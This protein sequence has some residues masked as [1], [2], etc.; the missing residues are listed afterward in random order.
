MIIV[1][2]APIDQSGRTVLLSAYYT[3]KG[4]KVILLSYKG[5][6]DIGPIKQNIQVKYLNYIDT[7]SKSGIWKVVALGAKFIYL[8]VAVLLYIIWGL[9]S[10]R[11]KKAACVMFVVPPIYTFIVPILVLRMLRKRVIIDWHRVE[12]KRFTSGMRAFAGAAENI[13]VTE[14]MCRF[15]RERK[16][17]NVKLKTDIY[18][19]K[20]M[21]KYQ[22]ILNIKR[23]TREEVFTVLMEKYSEYR[24]NLI[25]VDQKAAIGV[26]STSFS[27]EENVEEM[28]HGIQEINNV[29]G[30]LILTT[31]KEINYNH[32]SIKIIRMFLDYPDYLLLLSVVDFGISTHQCSYDYPLKIVDY[33][34]HSIP[35]IAHSSTPYISDIDHEKYIFRYN[36]EKMRNALISK[37]F[38]RQTPKRMEKAERIGN[39]DIFGDI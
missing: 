25:E 27:A 20:K 11:R 39:E 28:L 19:S 32:P 8:N 26:C 36:T 5:C 16:V 18:L 12:E 38:L 9:L 23:M 2:A 7:K 30:T 6:R 34:K 31:K 29:S 37:M 35:V 24:K 1:N 10:T 33:V 4:R 13:G 17:K 3:E 14:A 22:G 15:L 21:Q